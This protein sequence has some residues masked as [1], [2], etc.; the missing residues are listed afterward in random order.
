MRPAKVLAA[1]A[2]L[3]CTCGLP[4]VAQETANKTANGVEIKQGHAPDGTA[5][6]YGDCLEGPDQCSEAAYQWCHGPYR[7]LNPGGWTG[8]LRFICTKPTKPEHQQ[9]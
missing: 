8:V 3:F 5:Y 2:L 9:P 1:L 4:L 7:I 6:W